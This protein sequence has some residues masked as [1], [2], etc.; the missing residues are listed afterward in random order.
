MRSGESSCPSGRGMICNCSV[1]PSARLV[2]RRRRTFMT[3][4]LGGN[5]STC[6]FQPVLLH[7]RSW[8]SHRDTFGCTSL[9]WA[10]H[11]PT[12]LPVWWRWSHCLWGFECPQGQRTRR[13]QRLLLRECKAGLWQRHWCREC[14]TLCLACR[15][16]CGLWRLFIAL[17]W[18]ELAWRGSIRT[19]YACAL[20]FR[21]ITLAFLISKG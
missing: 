17:G 3:E 13:D 10:P 21:L 20:N 12:W 6:R 7:W 19:I 5:Q 16:S 9:S 14:K 11:L 1:R 4:C 18:R 15:R 8:P 2:L